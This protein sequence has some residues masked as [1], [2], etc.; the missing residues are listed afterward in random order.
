MIGEGGPELEQ[1]RRRHVEVLR[2]I[3]QRDSE[4]K[5]TRT[6]LKETRR[7][8]E[9]HF[10]PINRLNNLTRSSGRLAMIFE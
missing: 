10:P 4:D 8:E 9:Q 6:L 2:P 7:P 3:N 1:Q 5:P